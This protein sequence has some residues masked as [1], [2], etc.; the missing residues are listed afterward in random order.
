M[1]TF[2]HPSVTP[3]REVP[4]ATLD[5]EGADGR[6]PVFGIRG[7]SHWFGTGDARK[8][9]L[10]E[11]KLEVMPGE[12]VVMTGKSGSGKTT[13]L[14]LIGSLRGV[15][16]GSLQVLGREVTGLNA[17]QLVELRREIGFIFQAHNL[18]D[19]LTA[20]QNVCLA[21]QLREWRPGA[22]HGRAVELLTQLGL[23]DRL[24][25]KPGKL[26]GGQRQRVA[27]AR[28]LGN[29]PRLILADEPTA[30]LDEESAAWVVQLLR[31]EAKEQGTAVLIV[32]HDSCVLDAAD[33]IINLS[34]GRIISDVRHR[35]VS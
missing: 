24:H 28:A 33:R 15:Q 4:P 7:L 2:T 8:Q 25:Y 34:Y 3:M 29:H 9:V 14:T 23:E 32:T 27:V 1:T 12:I 26:S 6:R 17:G 18:F 19:S 22:M 21:L 35:E 16:Q 31:R 30:A 5:G 10:Y 20:Y 13:L 11:N